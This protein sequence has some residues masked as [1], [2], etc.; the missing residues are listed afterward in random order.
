MADCFGAAVKL[1]KIWVRGL[2]GLCILIVACCLVFTMVLALSTVSRDVFMIIVGAV[3]IV[4]APL[5]IGSLL[6]TVKNDE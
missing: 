3:F 4:I 1:F 6:E 5:V 2:E